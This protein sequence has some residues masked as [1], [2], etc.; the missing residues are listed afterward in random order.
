MGD[1]NYLRKIDPKI[2]PSRVIS[3]DFGNIGDWR[4]IGPLVDR[5]VRRVSSKGVSVVDTLDAG[6]AD[7]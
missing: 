4:R 1:R 2:N 3:A 5:I 6:R 7:R